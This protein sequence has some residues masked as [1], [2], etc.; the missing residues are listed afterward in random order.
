MEDLLCFWR[1]YLRKNLPNTSPPG[2]WI[3]LHFP[4]I[5]FIILLTL[6]SPAQILPYCCCSNLL[7]RS[8]CPSCIIGTCHLSKLYF[9]NTSPKCWCLCFTFTWPERIFKHVPQCLMRCWFFSPTHPLHICISKQ[10]THLEC[11]FIYPLPHADIAGEAHPLYSGPMKNERGRPF[12]FIRWMMPTS[13]IVPIPCSAAREGVVELPAD[14]KR[15]SKLSGA[16]ACQ[17]ARRKVL[18]ALGHGNCVVVQRKSPPLVGT[19]L[20]PVASL[21]SPVFAASLS[22]SIGAFFTWGWDRGCS[23]Q[24]AFLAV[25]C[26]YLR[27]RFCSRVK[28]VRDVQYHKEAVTWSSTDFLWG[29]QAAYCAAGGYRQIVLSQLSSRRSV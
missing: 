23:G 5:L 21:L 20:L 16:W 27:A 15:L 24:R 4:F 19:P 2:L 22:I 10:V 12:V 1:F 17:V 26:V 3:F 25:P 29:E 18:V 8:P 28:D 14:S 11:I 13:G 7:E 9:R 6:F